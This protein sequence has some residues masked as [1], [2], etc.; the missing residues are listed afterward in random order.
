[1][2]WRCGHQASPATVEL[3][4]SGKADVIF[5]IKPSL[6]EVSSQLPGSRVLED[7]PA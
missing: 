7:G 5:N 4:K 1:M 2:P 3:L 6:Y